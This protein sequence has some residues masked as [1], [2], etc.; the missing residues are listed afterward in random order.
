M[1][2]MYL[3][4]ILNINGFI[5]KN[6]IFLNGYSS[7][8]LKKL[9]SFS[10]SK[11]KFLKFF[12]SSRLNF[13]IVLEILASENK[14]RSF[15]YLCERIPKQIGKR[16]TIQN[17]LN[18]AFKDKMI[19]KVTCSNDKRIKYFRLTEKSIDTL[20]VLPDIFI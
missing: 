13:V 12:F 3:K 14:G 18:S 5:P 7:S 16:T 9:Y 4:N 2:K 1:E 19:H 8:I 10:S 17:C 11:D 20:K 6:K 15:E